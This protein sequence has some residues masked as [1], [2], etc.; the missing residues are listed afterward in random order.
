MTKI[1]PYRQ[2]KSLLLKARKLGLLTTEEVERALYSR[3]AL[4]LD[5][6][7]I[8][9][10]KEPIGWCGGIPQKALRVFALMS[11][12][13]E[14]A[15]DLCGKKISVDRKINK[16]LQPS[17]AMLCLIWGN[18]KL[19]DLPS[20]LDEAHFQLHRLGDSEACRLLSARAAELIATD[21]LKELDHKI[22]DISIQQLKQSTEGWK[23]F[24]IRCDEISVDVKNSRKLHRGSDHYVE[25][26]IP[27]FKK[28]RNDNQDIFIMGVLSPYINNPQKYFEEI[29]GATILGQVN[30]KEIRNLYR[31]AQKR[32]GKLLDLTGIWGSGYYPGWIFEY[33]SDH[34]FSRARALTSAPNLV[35]EFIAA[36]VPKENLPR[37]LRIFEDNKDGNL[38]TDE[39][40]ASERILRDLKSMQAEIGITKRSLYIYAMGITIEYL[41]QGQSPEDGI[42]ELRMHIQ[43]DS[44]T[45]SNKFFGLDDP[46]RYIDSLLNSL[47]T[48]SDRLIRQHT[49][50]LVFRL[51]HP[52]ILTGVRDDGTVLRLL[53]YCGGKFGNIQCASDPLVF[54]VNSNCP[55]CQYLI[56]K[57]CFGCAAACSEGLFRMKNKKIG[58][59]F[60]NYWGGYMESNEYDEGY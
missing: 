36:G 43:V 41:I 22:E 6:Q 30:I 11:K 40:E 2:F 47:A 8:D 32:F 46:L 54:G 7:A 17:D 21:Y 25:H 53:A 27:R 14:I 52:A 60:K 34:Y 12:A 16:P 35:S 15:D 20:S 28:N 1:P 13:E 44:E 18:I 56:C 38:F 3:D 23:Y 26:C 58:G 45:Q 51:I 42:N 59:N 57:N 4:V 39:S 55:S 29:V 24:D 33:S 50:I 10:G 9:S 49:R 31:W 37:W 19:E 48:V 5:Q